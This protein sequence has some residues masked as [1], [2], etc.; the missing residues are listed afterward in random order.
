MIELQSVVFRHARASA[1][2]LSDVTLTIPEGQWVSIVGPNGSGKS[3]LLK[4]IGGL[5]RPRAGQVIINKVPLSNETLHLVRQQIGFVFQNPENQFVGQTVQ[6][7]IVFGL[8]NQ[9]LDRAVM[10]ERL[11]RYSE[12]LGITELLPRYP[13]TLSG[14]QMQ[15]AALAAVL[16]MEPQILL[17]DE[18][19]S[20]LDEQGRQEILG[21]MRQLQASGRYTIVSVTH[22][23]EEMLA[24]NRVIGLCGGQ[25]IA[26]GLPKQVL[27]DDALLRK[28]RITPP[29]AARFARALQR[30]GVPVGDAWSE[31]ELMDE[32]WT[33][34]SNM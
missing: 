33:F 23:C 6:D 16:A 28:L 9:C 24:S 3:T 25:I 31:K 22:D 13:G 8:E 5:L 1:A 7:D 11:S 4:V 10:E 26:D 30:C 29:Y 19:T 12:H 21:I 15:R 14:G 20:M 32:L 18:A 34:D 27:A 2:V 17:F